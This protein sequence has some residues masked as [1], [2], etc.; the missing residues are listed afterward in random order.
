MKLKQI[1]KVFLAFAAVL[2]FM[3]CKKDKN[4]DFK[5]DSQV[6][7]ASYSINGIA[8]AIDQKTGAISVNVPF[9]TDISN[10]IPKVEM[11]DGATSSMNFDKPVNFTGAVDFRVMNG[12]LFKDYSTTV[13]I[14]PPRKTS[15][16]CPACSCVTGGIHDCFACIARYKSTVG[17]LQPAVICI[18]TRIVKVIGVPG[19]YHRTRTNQVILCRFIAIRNHL[20]IIAEIEQ[21]FRTQLVDG[22]LTS[23]A[24]LYLIGIIVQKKQFKLSVHI[25]WHHIANPS[26]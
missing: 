14:I 10:L 7:L 22:M 2:I 5:L 20:A 4:N 16:L 23:A 13:K 12:N 6:Q 15:L 19:F 1:L 24:L 18:I 9:G 25:A 8:A 17:I 3:G 11:P 21:V 26:C